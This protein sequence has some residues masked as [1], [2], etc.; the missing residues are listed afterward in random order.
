MQQIN[1]I[2]TQ[3]GYT[4]AATIQS[5]W[6]SPGGYYNVLAGAAYMEL[7][8]APPGQG[9]G[10]LTWTNE[11][12]I[13]VGTGALTQGT[14]GVRFRDAGSSTGPAVVTAAL[15]AE[16]EPVVVIGAP[17]NV[18]ATVTVSSAITGVIPAAGTVPTAGTGFT[19]THTNG[20]GVYVFT[21]NTPFATDA[22]V[23]ATPNGIGGGNVLY[24]PIITSVTA[25]GFTLTMKNTSNANADVPF[26]FLA[27]TVA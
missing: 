14:T 3:A 9:V 23:V 16:A 17:G 26:S 4:D 8:Y 27:T 10:G 2:T 7:Q 11:V 15:S 22:D 20:T 21:F 12:Y 5:V 6:N 24:F 1:Q 19:Y 13:P 18:T 25:N